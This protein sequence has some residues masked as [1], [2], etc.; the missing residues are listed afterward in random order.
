M[1]PQPLLIDLHMHTF[2]SDG[3][4][5][6]S[7]LVQRCIAAGYTAMA[8]TDH[9]DASN[10]EFLV[11]SACKIAD[12][13]N[14][15]PRSPI[16]VV[17]GVEITHVRPD[18][19]DDLIKQA[20]LLGARIV[21][22]HGETVVEPVPKGTNRAAIEA[23]AD[24]LAHPGLITKEEVALACKKGVALEIT[25][26]KMHG[27][28]NGHV[29]GLAREANA[30]LV[31]N[32]DSHA[33]GDLLTPAVRENTILGAGLDKSYLSKTTENARLLVEKIMGKVLG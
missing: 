25:T 14:A 15:Q 17:P 19:M 13:F 31:V 28:T 12:D 1:K 7:E 16:C 5:L 33:P 30:R 29:A 22:V 23:G 11:R 20:R 9:A 18:A 26:R 8:I 21:V 3:D 32:T 4:L 27:M 6:P 10:L 24:V 2:L